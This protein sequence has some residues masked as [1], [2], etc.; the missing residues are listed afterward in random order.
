MI[1]DIFRPL[2][3][4]KGIRKNVKKFTERAIYGLD[5]ETVKGKPYT[6]QIWGD[7]I[8]KCL[9]VSEENVTEKFLETILEHCESGG[10]FYVHNLEFDLAVLFY[11][12]LEN[13]KHNSFTIRG[14]KLRIKIL[15]G[16]INFAEITID[17]KHFRLIDTFAFFHTSLA[18]LAKTFQLP[19]KMERPRNLGNTKFRGKE[20]DYFIRYALRD[21][22]TGKSLGEK[23]V[24]FHRLFDIAPCISAPQLSAQV[25]KKQFIPAGL[26]IPPNPNDVDEASCLSYHGGKNGMYVEPGIYNGVR[27]YDINSAYPFAMSELPNFLS[28]GYKWIPKPERQREIDIGI[29]CISGHSRIDKYNLLRDHTFKPV[30]GPFEKLWITSYELQSIIKHNWVADLILHEAFIVEPRNLKVNPL[31]DFSLKFFDL[32]AREK[33]NLREFYKIIL[34]SLYGK[35]IQNVRD[36][37]T[38]LENVGEEFK[39]RFYQ[40]GGLWNPLIATLITGYV[41]AYLT[42]LEVRYQSLHSSTDS[43]MTKERIRETKALGGL[44]LKATGTALLIRP[45]LYIVWNRKREIL[46]YALHG[47]HGTLKDF[48][49]MMRSGKRTYFHIR[50]RKV[51][52]SFRQKGVTPLVMQKMFK[53]INIPIDKPLNIPELTWRGEKI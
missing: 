40:A 39:E 11:P 52:E 20:R 5:T 42:E 13:F 22:E 3:L 14:E 53:Q 38:E 49:R 51:R 32:K 25:F 31:R 28:C 30:F 37:T 15:C 50:M 17:D 10:I 41:R 2:W 19:E 29:Y 7:K 26:R 23:I 9:F 43:I 47:Y 27:V 48:V 35:F 16:K 6:I 24:D 1:R 21:A 45:K 18:S 36:D 33:G 4:R 34:N 46:T 8:Q 12:F 44:S